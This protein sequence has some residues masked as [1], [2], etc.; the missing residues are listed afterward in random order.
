MSIIA[1]ATA[2][3]S[4]TSYTIQSVHST[5]NAA[6]SDADQLEGVV[7]ALTPANVERYQYHSRNVATQA[8]MAAKMNNP[9][10]FKGTPYDLVLLLSTNLLCSLTL[11]GLTAIDNALQQLN[12]P[13]YAKHHLV[14]A[15]TQD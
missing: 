1:L 11:T 15:Y 4:G 9:I 12:T 5:Y 14:I 3:P 10:N 7:I 6:V 2:T 13:E 8:R